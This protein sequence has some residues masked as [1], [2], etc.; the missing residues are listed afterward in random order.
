M[1]SHPAPAWRMSLA[2]SELARIAW[3]GEDGEARVLALHFAVAQVRPSWHGRPASRFGQGDDTAYLPGVVWRLSGVVV[4]AEVADA[5]AVGA[6]KALAAMLNQAP[7]RVSGGGLRV[8]ADGAGKLE[9]PLAG[10]S[11]LRSEVPLPAEFTTA[12]RAGIVLRLDL[13]H[14]TVLTL[15]ASGLRCALAAGLADDAAGWPSLAC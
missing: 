9:N 3:E 6:D 13:A 15:R 7:G 2:G 10:R 8:A 14:G 11:E 12:E 1:A 4:A 5:D